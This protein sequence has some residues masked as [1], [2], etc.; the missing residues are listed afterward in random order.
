MFD[1]IFLGVG[2]DGHT[3]SL[4]PGRGPEGAAG[5]AV[6]VVTGDPAVFIV[7]VLT[8]RPSVIRVPR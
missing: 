3:A 7:S 2:N 8:T 6:A 5:A 1:L 4:F